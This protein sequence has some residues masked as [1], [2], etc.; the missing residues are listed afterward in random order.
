MGFSEA[1]ERAIHFKDGPALVLAGPGSGK[2]T[3]ITHRVKALI[4]RHGVP[5]SNIL[6]ITF[7][8][9]A[10]KE[11]QLRFLTLMW[12]L[13]TAV[14]F[15]T[16]HAVYFSILRHA[17]HYSPKSIITAAGQ[18]D[19]IRNEISMSELEYEDEN[20][21]ISQILSEIGRV[22]NE[23]LQIEE[24]QASSC[25]PESFKR[26]FKNYENM[27][28][29]R[30]MIDF[31]D[32][33]L[34]SFRLLSER[35]DYLLAWQNKYRYILIDEFQD[36]NQAQFDV[37]RLIAQRERNLFV[38]GDDDQS[39]Y[40]FRGSKPEIMLNFEKCFIDAVR[41]ELSVNYR[42]AG[43][44]VYAAKSLIDQNRIRFYKN[45]RMFHDDGEKVRVCEFD[46]LESEKRF[47]AEEIRALKKQG[48]RFLDIAVLT[49]TNAIG[50][51]YAE[52]F[53]CDGLPCQ[54]VK[55]RSNLY[56]YWI[57]RD[58]EAYLNIA[59][60]QR[61]RQEFLKIINKPVRYISR[62][63]LTEP[64]SFEKLR[65]CYHDNP[66]M[67]DRINALQFD[68]KMMKNMTGFAALNYI[69]QGM[70]YN[71]YMDEYIRRHKLNREEALGVMD[72]LE[73]HAKQFDSITQWLEYI[74]QYR[75]SDDN[76]DF[77][78]EGHDIDAIRLYTMHS[79]KGLEFKAVFI[80]D[81]CEGIIPYNKALLEQE[82]EEERRMFY[83]AMTRS[84]EKLYL[85][86]PLQRYNR[87]TI[88]SRFIEEIDKSRVSYLTE[89][90]EF[91][92]IIGKTW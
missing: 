3:V 84:K 77:G 6:V 21:G 32:M 76:A 33:I 46:S 88:V 20:E 74:S 4:E 18:Y 85:C 41:I 79:A 9:A 1:Q 27:L 25:P 53:K 43:N 34:M 42:S 50:Q 28:L 60:G 75:S 44:I 67:I 10:A 31:E 86:Y 13:G 17:Y 59:A 47:I 35:S 48:M 14:T 66:D 83:V 58:I 62:S 64:V 5:P 69:R 92:D 78:G 30:R 89:S 91:K 49:R 22:K 8:K 56:D 54:S 26:I 72:E 51:A 40:G 12:D 57:A 80:T 11:M 37:I 61:S 65:N 2:T 70:E 52:R 81:V 73:H 90:K 38:V 87:S 15:G 23:R 16:F 63:F 7:S 29:G 39:I 68:I 55:G 45:I 24:Y 82:I 19:F 36:I 71:S